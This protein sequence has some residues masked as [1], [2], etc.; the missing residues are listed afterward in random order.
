MITFIVNFL[1]A[2]A[3]TLLLSVS[4][5]H[6]SNSWAMKLIRLLMLPAVSLFIALTVVAGG[7]IMMVDFVL[8]GTK[9]FK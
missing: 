1:I 6:N 9:A 5:F 3:Y 2:V 4:L 8:F 7:L